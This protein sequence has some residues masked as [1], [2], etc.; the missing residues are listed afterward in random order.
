MIKAN[1]NAKSA[2]GY[3]LI[4]VL[5]GMMILSIA[6]GSAFSLSVSVNRTM[7]TNQRIT[8]ASNLAEYKLEELRNLPYIGIIDGADTGTLDAYGVS[9]G[10]FT[11]SWTV[12]TDTPETGLKSVTVTVTWPQWSDTRS[13]SMTAVIG[14]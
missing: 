4:E 9:P 7:L 5:I 10:R 8:A 1:L 13:Y 12:A 11:R 3:S 6:I 14:S 2:A